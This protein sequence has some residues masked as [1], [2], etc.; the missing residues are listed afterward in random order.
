MRL[1]D[2]G[3]NHDLAGRAGANRD[4]GCSRLAVVNARAARRAL[5]RLVRLGCLERLARRVGGARA[6]SAGFI[7]RLAPAGQRLATLRGWQPEDRRRRSQVPG[8]LFVDHTLQVA[9]L[10]TL[11]VEADRSRTIELLELDAEPACH[12]RYGGIGGQRRVLK[13]DSY[14]RLGAGDYE[15]S[16]FIEVDMG[17]EGSQALERQ[18]KLYLDYEASGAE[19][20]AHGVFPKCLWLVPSAERV[21]VIEGCVGRLPRSAH[22]LFQVALFADAVRV[23]SDTSKETETAQR[24]ALPSEA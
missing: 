15:D 5:L 11:L 2:A 9:E 21:A 20:A 18:L 13:P 19:Q 22:E 3:G 8:T 7:Y 16:Y 23:V 4:R 12:R 1:D 10:H 17:T 6:G 24:T 14:A